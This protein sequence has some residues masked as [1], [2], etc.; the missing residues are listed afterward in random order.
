M[1]L[2]FSIFIVASAFSFV[3]YLYQKHLYKLEQLLKAKDLTEYKV[4]EKMQ[5]EAKTMIPIEPED[6]QDNIREKSPQEI[7]AMFTP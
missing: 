4:M 1:E 5:E 7:R 2:V 3:F 6:L